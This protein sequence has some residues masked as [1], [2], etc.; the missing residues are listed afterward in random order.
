MITI[1]LIH[2]AAGDYCII[3]GEH[4]IAG[5]DAALGGRVIQIWK[6][7][8]ADVVEALGASPPEV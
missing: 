6:V 2:G 4:C 3:L 5:D 7:D 1:Q 8:R